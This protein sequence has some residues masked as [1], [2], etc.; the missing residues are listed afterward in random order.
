MDYNF[1]VS[2]VGLTTETCNESRSTGCWYIIIIVVQWRKAPGGR[3]LPMWLSIPLPHI[4]PSTFKIEINI[5]E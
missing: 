4:I 1:I 3:I 5:N 2:S